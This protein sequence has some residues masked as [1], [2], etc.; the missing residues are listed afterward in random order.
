MKYFRHVSPS[1]KTL[2]HLF[3]PSKDSDSSP[4]AFVIEARN[5]ST[6][7]YRILWFSINQNRYAKKLAAA[8]VMETLT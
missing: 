4:D 8:N 6:F 1:P 3:Q 7:R 2:T 5:E